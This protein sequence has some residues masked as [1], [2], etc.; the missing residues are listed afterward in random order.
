[1][2]KGLTGFLVLREGKEKERKER[3][4]EQEDLPCDFGLPGSGAGLV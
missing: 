3:G 4:A 2:K 1:M